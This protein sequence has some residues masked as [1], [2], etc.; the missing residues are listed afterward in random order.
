MDKPK[1]IVDTNEYIKVC[2][3]EVTTSDGKNFT[4][5]FGYVFSINAKGDLINRTHTVVDKDGKAKDIPVSIRV[6]L[7]NPIKDKLIKENNFPYMLAV[8][9]SRNIKEGSSD[10]FITKDKKKDGTLRLDKNGNFHYIMVISDCITYYHT[11]PT[12]VSL[13]DFVNEI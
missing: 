4:T 11:D 10:Y 2:S 3:K 12:S 7:M 5:Y 9:P 1:M 13:T 8:D 6:H